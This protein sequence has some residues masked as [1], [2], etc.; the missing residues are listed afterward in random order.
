MRFFAGIRNKHAISA[1]APQKR[2]CE[3]GLSDYQKAI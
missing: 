2:A 3:Y 1:Y